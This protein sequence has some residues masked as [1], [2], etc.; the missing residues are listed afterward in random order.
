MKTDAVLPRK[1]STA[2]VSGRKEYISMCAISGILNHHSVSVAE[3]IVKKMTAAQTHRGPDEDGFFVDDRVALG[4]RRLAVIDLES[5]Q[6]PVSRD[7]ITAI[8]NGEIY[9][10][11]D[12]RRELE[13]IGH[14]FSTNSD[15]EVLVHLYEQM[16]SEFLP[17][18]SGMFAFVIYDSRRQRV[19]M[20]RDRIG[21]KPLVYF[22]HKDSLVFASELCGLRQ[23]PDMSTELD[24]N[25]L[26]DYFS[27]QYIP[28]P[29]TVYRKVRKLAP[30]YLLD[31]KL[32][33]GALSLRPY[34]NLSFALKP[35]DLSF[36]DASH[37]LRELVEK[38][39][40]RRLMSDV[41]L[42]VFL[43]GGID[44]TIIAGTAAKL[45][46]PQKCN[47]YTVGFSNAAYDERS[48][49]RCAAEHINR[50]TGNNL[51]YHEEV[52]EPGSFDL[53]SDL[54]AQIGQPFADASI[55]PTAQLSRFARRDITVALSGD[56]ADE[57]FCG[58]DRYVAMRL[59]HNAEILPDFVRKRIFGALVP[60]LPDSGERTMTG[61]LRRLFRLLG[62]NKESAYFDLLDRCPASLKRNLAGPRMKEAVRRRSG[63]LFTALESELTAI[64]R[65]ERCS[66]TDI[67]TYLPGDILVKVDAA[68]MSCGLEVRSPFFDR[69][70]V[71]FAAKLPM[72][73]K[74]CGMNRKRI[75]KEA[76]S[77]M[78]PEELK[79]R[80]KRGFGV[81]VA[82]W[83]RGPWHARAEE[84]LFESD[85]CSD[86]FVEK[87]E[88]KRIWNC[89][90]SGR[91]DWS[92][93]LWSLLVFGIFLE[94]RKHG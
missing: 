65:E 15:T 33:G 52:I 8:L 87:T 21:K 45:L 50:L 17:L 67:H 31:F 5:G 93:L 28:E 62:A 23:H 74:L 20:A 46:A 32:D 38:A 34:W 88:L 80:P 14:T 27:L 78:I 37:H 84:V 68:S 85:L 47:A 19:L 36:E 81:P 73:Y 51:V 94:N 79:E 25:S 77:D 3:N 75:L 92:Y 60:L 4:H 58:Y 69:E 43:S 53:L 64:D 40:S 66:E 6:Q 90:C 39:V 30:G 71:E 2:G 57:L 42:G 49:A 41:P 44:S 76:F 10:Y 91:G 7:G 56:G 61:R 16:G 89:H 11:R 54:I 18:I 12:L 83:L 13:T 35:L 9:N 48:Y 82:H 86:G 1:A 29:N 24:L 55:L 70:V 59:L 72:K 26:S 63:E 22:L